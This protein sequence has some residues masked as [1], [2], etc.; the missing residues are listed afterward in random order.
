MNNTENL[1]TESITAEN[2]TPENNRRDE[3]LRRLTALD[4]VA[5]DMGLYLNTHPHCHD[6]IEKYNAAI[7]EADKCRQMYESAYGPLCSFRSASNKTWCWSDNPW[8]WQEE[9]N[10]E[11][12][13]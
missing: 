9:F 7:S 5:V 12:H 2:H 1:T 3:L 8:P 6:A 10:F 4:F 11:L 13:H